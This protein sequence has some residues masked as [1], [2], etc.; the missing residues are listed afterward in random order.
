MVPNK[1]CL[2]ITIKS[3]SLLSYKEQYLLI[4]CPLSRTSHKSAIL[5]A[6]TA[7][8]EA[9]APPV[10]ILITI[11]IGIDTLTAE[12]IEKI[13]KSVNEVR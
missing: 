7:C 2:K 1:I 5:P 8:T 10:N 4:A 6:P 9:A 13:T 3:C 11:S 12:A